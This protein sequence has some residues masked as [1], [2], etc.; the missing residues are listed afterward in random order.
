VKTFH[1]TPARPCQ[2]HFDVFY[3]NNYIYIYMYSYIKI[4]YILYIMSTVVIVSALYR[5]KEKRARGPLFSTHI[6][7]GVPG[8]S[9]AE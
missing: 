2:V 7:G 9:A 4:L 3:E 8:A 6:I 1:H 5:V